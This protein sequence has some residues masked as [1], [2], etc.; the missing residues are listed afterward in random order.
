MSTLQQGRINWA[1]TVRN[2]ALWHNP[3]YRNLETSNRI[4]HESSNR[5][6]FEWKSEDK[7][8]F[9]LI[10]TKHPVRLNTEANMKYPDEGNSFLGGE[11]GCWKQNDF[12][13]GKKLD[14]S[15]KF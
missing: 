6:I 3:S 11:G 1:L 7:L 13:S 15:T 9:L 14:W 10:K 12:E 8:I 5:R 2:A 4:H